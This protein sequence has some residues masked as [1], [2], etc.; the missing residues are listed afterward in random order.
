MNIATFP[1]GPLQTNCYVL[2]NGKEALVVDPG[3]DPG[4][5]LRH[6]EN[7]G[8]TLTVILNTHLHF[9]HT[10]GNK[11]L[12]DATGAPV[13]ANDA[14]GYLLDNWLG[15]GGDMGLPSI[16]PYKWQNL[17]QGETVFAGAAC[18]VLHTPGHSPGSLTFHFPD[19]GAAFVGDLIFYRSIG[20]TDFPGGDIEALKRSVNEHIF[21]MPPETRLLSGHGPETSVGD[22]RNHNPFFG[23]F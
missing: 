5:V 11:A 18:R 21:T 4:P 14:D 2:A 23:G 15:A 1:L 8:L 19:A 16:A 9:D 20:R 7:E 13:M 3:G 12:S 17:E 6:L 22:E 10:A